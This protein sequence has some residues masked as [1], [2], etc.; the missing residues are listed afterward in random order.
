MGALVALVGE[1]EIARVHRA[2][3]SSDRVRSASTAERGTLRRGLRRPVSVG[4]SSKTEALL[5]VPRV[6][7]HPPQPQG[8]ALQHDGRSLI[9]FDVPN[10]VVPVRVEGDGFPLRICDKTMQVS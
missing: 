1:S 4:V 8:F 9:V 10:C 5:D 6:R 2:A 7:L 3:F